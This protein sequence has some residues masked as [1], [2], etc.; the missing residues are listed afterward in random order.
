[1]RQT[2]VALQDT[3]D[4]QL[5][6]ALM[7][8]IEHSYTVETLDRLAAQAGLTLVTPCLNAYDHAAGTFAWHLRFQEPGLQA[9][10]D[11]LPD[12]HRWQVTNLLLL[13][14]SPMLWFYLQRQDCPTP[15][16]TEQAI[17]D[18]MLETRFRRTR[19][20]TQPY[21]RRPDQGFRK[22]A[23]VPHPGSAPPDLRRLLDGIDAREPLGAAL[24]RLGLAR[25]F[26]TVTDLRSRLT[27][28]AFAHL[29]AVS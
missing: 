7:Q 10:Y 1:M 15:R 25:D 6:D 8:P 11:A 23:P 17:A 2:L 29:T 16:R 27:T 19:T 14:R 4:V 20:E 18:A 9:T 28:S 21:V 24:D 26:S 3:P 5:A 12:A 22:A 13:E